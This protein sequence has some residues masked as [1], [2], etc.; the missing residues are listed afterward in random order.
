MN[1]CLQNL[2]PRINRPSEHIWV[3]KGCTGKV[4]LE[5]TG[6]IKAWW[7]L[8]SNPTCNHRSAGLKIGR[9]IRDRILRHGRGSGGRFGHITFKV[10]IIMLGK[11]CKGLLHGSKALRKACKSNSRSTSDSVVGSSRMNFASP[12]NFSLQR[13][14]LSG[15]KSGVERKCTTC[16]SNRST[17]KLCSAERGAPARHSR[18]GERGK[19]SSNQFSV[20]IRALSTSYAAL[21]RRILRLRLAP[22]LS[23]NI[24]RPTPPG[25]CPF[26]CGAGAGSMEALGYKGG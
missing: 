2:G 8:P 17:I 13:P 22:G 10:G 16:R 20:G 21:R 14:K 12:S 25:R 26:I 1:L 9:S 23:A 6:W 4:I 24:A 18:Q 11:R 7:V 5:K 3:C 19:P 15:P